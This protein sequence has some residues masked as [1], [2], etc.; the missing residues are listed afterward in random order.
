MNSHFNFS[1]QTN[2]DRSWGEHKLNATLLY[3][4][5][6]KIGQ[7]QNNKYAFMDVVAQ[8]HY[9]YKNRYILDFALSG[10][11]SSVLEPGNRWGIFP[12]IGA[13]WI[14]SEEDWLKSDN[15]NLLKLR[16]S[17]GI[18]GRA[19]FDANLYKYY[20]GSGNSYYFK[21]TPTSQSGMKEYRIAVDGLTYESLTN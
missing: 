21:D 6:K 12:S 11:A 14:L 15:L 2:Y 19:D 7:G 1:A 3:S 16:A 20:F 13:G 10:S 18:A 9:T 5:D 8:G 4:M 17:Y